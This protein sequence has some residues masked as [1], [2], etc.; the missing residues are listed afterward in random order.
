[1][2]SRLFP[3]LG[4]IASLWLEQHVAGTAYA[5]SG[6]ALMALM[7]TFILVYLVFGLKRAA[8][9]VATAAAMTIGAHFGGPVVAFACA[10]PAIALVLWKHGIL[11]A[12]LLLGAGAAAFFGWQL[13]GAW[14]AVLYCVAAAMAITA[15]YDV[16][17]WHHSLR[18]AF[19]LLARLR[20][21]AEMIRPEIQQYW[22]E[23]DTDNRPNG[24]RQDW[25]FCIGASKNQLHDISL[26]TSK[27]YHKPGQIHIRNQTFPISDREEIELA[28]LVL[29]GT[30]RNA[31]NSLKC[32]TPAF[33]HGRFG[34][35]DMSFGSLGQNAVESL[36]S[37]AGRSGILLS[38]GEG[39][40]TPYHLNGTR[41][42]PSWK[43][44]LAWG[45]AYPLSFV[46][47]RWRRT[48]APKS[49]YL[50]SGQIMLELGTAKFGCRTAD[51]D[52]DYEKFAKLSAN[53]HVVA[54]KLKLAQ[55]AKPGG[56]GILPAAK[57]TAE[58]AAIRGIPEGKDCLSPNVW[59][60]FHD[61]PSM[62]AFIAKLQE[63]SGKPVGIKIVIG[64]EDFINEVGQWMKDHDN[65]GPDFIHVDGGEGGTGAAPLPLADYVGLPIMQ[66]LPIVDNV[67]RKYG[68]RHRVVVMS[69]GKV[70]NPAH[71]FIQLALGAD[72]V[73]GARAFMNAL[74]CIGARR[75]A[76]GMCPTGIATHEKWLQ[77][78]LMPRV[79]YIRVANFAEVMH[80]WLKKMLRV[81]GHRDTFELS[82][83][84]LTIVVGVM[85]ELGMNEVVPYPEGIEASRP[86]F[87]PERFGLRAPKNPPKLS[88]GTM[89]CDWSPEPN[90]A[91]VQN[92]VPQ[93]LFKL[94][95]PVIN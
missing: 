74:G 9:V 57:V 84:D 34:I 77:R 58:I 36:A 45:V 44:K 66:A 48:D 27:D 37:G 61:V 10:I 14:M 87:T 29:G 95:L 43:E 39:G 69:S 78:A 21:L 3:A 40:L 92:A 70:F 53:P 49:G 32:K 33:I 24:T 93:Q 76:E 16:F 55:G 11:P 6:L 94:E 20:W 42:D 12:T 35:G 60:E 1:M 4:I 86:A 75:C 28:P 31:D 82:R 71:L 67:L 91:H 7:F 81:S 46:S 19:P 62:M 17:Q 2:L 63:I 30:R 68:V 26:G 8:T 18:R 59:S 5:G 25:E 79:K 50:G 80:K 56:G 85:K 51:G 38:T 64:K 23:R 52:F 47:K 22:I 72:Y 89:G 13:Q 83:K 15:V 41:I 54:I 88:V 90:E 65:E 73:F